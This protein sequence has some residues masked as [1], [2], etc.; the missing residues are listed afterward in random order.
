MR[1]LR[2]TIAR[3]G[4]AAAAVLALVAVPDAA[5]T[6]P[7]FGEARILAQVPNPPGFPEGIAVRGNRVYVAGPATFG[8]TGKP[9]SAV[10]AFDVKTGAPLARYD[11]IGE[12][13]LA[14]HANSSIAF[15]DDGRLYVLNTQLGMYRLNVQT[16]EQEPY[17]TPFPDLLPCSPATPAPCSPTVANAPPIPNDLAFDADGNAY[18]SDSMQATIWKVP[19]GGGD[20]QVWFQDTRLASPYIGVNGLRIDP[21]GEWVFVTVTTDMSGAAFVYVLPLLAAP[22]AADLDTFHAFAPGDMPD[23]IAFGESGLLYVAMAT[24]GRSG[25]LALEPSGLEAFWLANPEGSP[26]APYDSPANIAF[27]GRGSIVLTN[28]AFVSG[29]A[30]PSQFSIAIAYVNDDAA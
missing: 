27:D 13:L 22:S 15:G 26:L 5:A 11:V 6:P 30:A 28:H 9:A 17:S 18:V 23:G 12:D 8:T 25:V 14:E 29:V 10:L 7:V 3:G 19:A 2:S 1:K 24:P 21:T 20:P 4:L 16:G